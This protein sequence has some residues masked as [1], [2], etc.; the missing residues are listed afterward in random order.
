VPTY[1]LKRMAIRFLGMAC[2]LAP[3]AI[4]GPLSA[5]QGQRVNLNTVQGSLQQSGLVIAGCQVSSMTVRYY[6]SALVGQP[7][8]NGSYTWTAG[9]GTANDCLPQDLAVWIRVEGSGTY[10]YVNI[11]PVVPVAGSWGYNVSGSPDWDKY[12][13]GFQENRA[14]QCFGQAEAIAFW[15]GGIRVTGFSPSRGPGARPGDPSAQAQQQALAQQQAQQAAEQQRQQAALAQQQE[16]ER[17]QAAAQQQALAQRQAAVNADRAAAQQYLQQWQ[18]QLAQQQTQMLQS[19]DSSDEAD[20]ARERQRLRDGL[21]SDAQLLETVNNE[22]AQASPD[23]MPGVLQSAADQLEQ[24]ADQ[25]DHDANS[26]A[27]LGYN[28]TTLINSLGR[29]L[30]SRGTIGNTSASDALQRKDAAAEALEQAEQARAQR[31]RDAASQL[32]Q[33]REALGARAPAPPAAPAAAYSPAPAPEAPADIPELN[34]RVIGLKFYEGGDPG[35]AWGQRQYATEF[36]SAEA[37][38]I[39]VELRFRSAPAAAAPPMVRVDCEYF[40]PNGALMGQAPMNLGPQPGW[41]DWYWTNNGLGWATPGHYQRGQYFVACS[42]EGRRIASGAFTIGPHDMPMGLASASVASFRLDP[43]SIAYRLVDQGTP[44]GHSSLRLQFLTDAGRAVV[45]LIDSAETGAVLT[46]DTT[47]MNSVTLGP[48]RVR[49]ASTVRDSLRFL[50][51]DYVAL[52][53]TGHVQTPSRTA[54]GGHAVAVDTTLDEP[55][56]DG[57]EFVPVLLALPLENGMRQR[58]RFYYGVR[59]AVQETTISVAGEEEVT[60]PA[61]TFLC[62]RLDVATLGLA[63]LHVYVTTTFPRMMVKY[64]PVGRQVS[65]EMTS[66]HRLI[67]W[68]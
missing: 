29:I 16:R 59:G 58:A 43:I 21:A 55:A 53:V 20:V 38:Y 15:N 45:R 41:T 14:T 33:Q 3:L 1:C 13:C 8:V 28:A 5:Q 63:Y 44:V 39:F 37:R 24:Q 19:Y 60:V 67:G 22:V 49:E 62:W 64:E 50:R 11:N 27:S 68:R 9:P 65:Y 57:S 10:A 30:A 25:A 4:A 40:F 51:L 18:A 34:A 35:P 52:H 17:E 48:I 42:Y 6:L 46:V 2:M 32:Q 23:Q 61:G 54:S 66:Y 47:T 26:A 7:V 56:F 31:L 12:F 36:D